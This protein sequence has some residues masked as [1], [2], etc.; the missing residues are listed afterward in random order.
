MPSTESVVCRCDSGGD[1][2]HVI[3]VERAAVI[4]HGPGDAC[5]FVSERD[6]RFV[7]MTLARTLERPCLELRQRLVGGSEPA[8]SVERCPSTV[9]EEHADIG[10]SLLADATQPPTTT[11]RELAR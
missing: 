9:H 6:G 3:A 1:P 7:G 5:E 4:P 2:N 8:G 11:R 10:I